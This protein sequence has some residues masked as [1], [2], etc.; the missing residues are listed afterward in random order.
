[1]TLRE[2]LA[3]LVAETKNSRIGDPVPHSWTVTTSPEDLRAVKEVEVPRD[4]GVRR[5]QGCRDFLDG[6]L[7]MAV[8]V[9]ENLDPHRLGEQREPLGNQVHRKLVQG[10]TSFAFHYLSLQA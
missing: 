4:C 9:V 7:I 2:A 8:E 5:A 6:G 3:D 1:M 10:A